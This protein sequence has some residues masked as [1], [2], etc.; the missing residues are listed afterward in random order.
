MKKILTLMMLSTATLIAAA[1]S[2]VQGS[3]IFDNWSLSLVGGGMTP[4]A[5]SAFFGGMRPTYGLEL[6]KKLTP[7]VSLA[8]Q[9]TMANNVSQ[10]ATAVDASNVTLLGKFNL[11][12]LFAGYTGRPRTFEL[13]A[14]AGAGWGHAYNNQAVGMDDNFMTSKYGL[15]L[16]FNLGEERA[17]TVSL[18]PSVVYNMEGGE[19][20][21]TY[22]VNQAALELMAGVTYHF[23]NANNGKHHFTLHRGYDQT[24]V[25]A[26][27]AKVNDLWEILGD[28]EV[29]VSALAVQNSELREALGEAKQNTRIVEQEVV[30]AYERLE[31]VVTFRKGRSSIDASQMPNVERIAIYM[32]NHPESRVDIKGYASPEGNAEANQ[33]LAS[34]RAEAV[35]Q[36]LVKKYG[37]DAQR[38]DA[39]GQGVGNLFS[40]PDWNRV[41]I[42]TIVTRSK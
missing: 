42:A 41:S 4:V 7:V 37:I 34:K 16:N 15:N 13:E 1:Q 10:S 40:E 25:D 21:P 39:K 30:A 32:K 29:E 33:K 14:V 18:K 3:G 9:G 11:T 26:L 5:H 27:N 28:K 23:R 12:N 36:M 20:H 6:T 2:T 24:E 19:S 31:S 35:K 17:W 8:V 38:I 22:N